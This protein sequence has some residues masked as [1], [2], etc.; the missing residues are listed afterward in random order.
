VAAQF[1]L[2]LRGSSLPGVAGSNPAVG[3]DD[4]LVSVVCCQVQ[5][6]ASGKSLIKRRLLAVVCLSVIVKLR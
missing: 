3:M 4:L 5:V 2:L 6:S 1:N